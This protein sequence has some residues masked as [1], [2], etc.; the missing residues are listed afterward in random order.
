MNAS[1]GRYAQGRSRFQ[2]IM[3]HTR[4]FATSGG[5]SPATWTAKTVIVLA[6]N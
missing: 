4:R 6:S 3:A 1:K 5:M 2:M